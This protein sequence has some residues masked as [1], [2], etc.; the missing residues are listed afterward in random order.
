MFAAVPFEQKAVA[1]RLPDGVFHDANGPAVLTGI[2][3]VRSQPQPPC[4]IDRFLIN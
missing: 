4:F 1:P 2:F 3:P